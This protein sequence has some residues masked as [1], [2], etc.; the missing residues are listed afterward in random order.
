MLG[1][2]IKAVIFSPVHLSMIKDGPIERRKFIDNALCQ[3][4][5]NYRNA[6]KEYNRCLAQRNIVLRDMQQYGGLD[7]ILFVWNLNFAKTCS[8]IIYQRQKYVEALLPMRKRFSKVF[9]QEKKKLISF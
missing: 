9:L 1:E 2:D 6:L 5:S 3:L 7:E 4:N 8:K